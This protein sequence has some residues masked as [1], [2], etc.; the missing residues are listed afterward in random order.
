M[1]ITEGFCRKQLIYCLWIF[2]LLMLKP[3]FLLQKLTFQRSFFISSFLQSTKYIYLNKTRAFPLKRRES[4]SIF[5]TFYP[6]VIQHYCA[7]QINKQLNWMKSILS[8][9]WNCKYKVVCTYWL[10]TNWWRYINSQI[11]TRN[12]VKLYIYLS[13]MFCPHRLR[14]KI[15]P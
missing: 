15:R 10:P 4:N 8:A 11:T 9:F 14:N 7:R 3:K 6:L 13:L 1:K 5:R 12:I 2:T